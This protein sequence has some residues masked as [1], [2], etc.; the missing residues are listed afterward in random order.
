VA[1]WAWVL[2]TRCGVLVLV[3]VLALLC[4]VVPRMDHMVASMP[5]HRRRTIEVTAGELE[6]SRKKL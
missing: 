4:I 6:D 2:A 3:L 1:L 5:Q